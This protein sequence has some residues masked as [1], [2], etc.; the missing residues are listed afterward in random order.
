MLEMVWNIP[1]P[2]VNLRHP[3]P[4]LNLDWSL[5]FGATKPQ[6]A[7]SEAT[8]SC[9]MSHRDPAGDALHINDQSNR[10]KVGIV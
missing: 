9:S 1:E 3:C 8:D 6:D 5:R 7:S 10:E 2:P 4:K